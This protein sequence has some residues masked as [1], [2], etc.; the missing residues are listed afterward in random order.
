VNPLENVRIEC[1][2]CGKI[3]EVA[4]DCLEERQEYVEDCQV[5]CHPIS[6][7]IVNGEDGPLVEARR[8]DE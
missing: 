4:V 6:L 3:I 2:Y 7:R 8:H 1:P 5:C